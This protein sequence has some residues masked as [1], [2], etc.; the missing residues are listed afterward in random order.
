MALMF[1]SAESC[2]IHCLR[3]RSFPG[4]PIVI[5]VALAACQR[6]RPA[7]FHPAA[8]DSAFNAAMGHGAGATASVDS[9]GPAQWKTFYIFGPYTSVD[10]IRR[11]LA[12]SEFEPY[13]IE[14]RDDV[15]VV[16]FRSGTSNISSM[17][18][19]RGTVQFASDALSREYPRDSATF[20][21]R[22]SPTGHR[23]L[24]PRANAGRSCT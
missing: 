10:A 11:C 16:Y 14:H 19:P 1:R 20:V 3:L 23:E 8:V 12:T 6:D 9:L 18:I 4:F 15:Y 5:L 24:A 13:G 22:L 7:S 17:T 2:A 21:V